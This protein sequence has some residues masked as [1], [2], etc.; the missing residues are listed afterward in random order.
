MWKKI[1]IFFLTA[2]LLI[3]GISWPGLVGEP[4]GAEAAE[5]YMIYFDSQEGSQVEPIM[6]LAYGSYLSSLPVPVREGYVFEGWYR[7]P[8][9]TNRFYTYSPIYENMVLFAKWREKGI[10]YLEVSYAEKTAI[11]GTMLDK[12]KILVKAHYYD[13][14][15]VKLL[16]PEEFEIVDSM[17]KLGYNYFKVEVKGISA[18]FNV[19][20]IKEPRYTVSFYSNGGS[21]VAPTPDIRPDQTISMPAEPTRDGYEFKG[22]YLDNNTFQ[23]PFNSEYKINKSIIVFAKWEKLEVIVEE[24]EYDLNTDYIEL[25]VSEQKSL[26][27]ESYDE[28][29]EV[30]YFSED[31]DIA[32]VNGE[33]IVEGKAPGAVSVF[34]VTPEGEMLECSVVVEGIEARSIKLNTTAK[35]LKKGKSF[36]IKTSFSPSNVSTKK[37]KYSSTNKKIAKVSSKGKVTALKKGTCYIRVKTVD[38]SGL[39]KKL[40]IRVY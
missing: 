23:K 9:Y 5:T 31:E 15:S 34:V 36:Q 28:Y 6:N 20:G 38:G 25:R 24:P 27:I 17:V 39:T 8:D 30:E 14:N 32:T 33:G 4:A 19:L 22:W 3:T 13:D 18:Y 35:S 40:K 26:F 1:R 16:K 29:L 12:E 2:V 11:E 7:E 37:L 10:S 21:Y